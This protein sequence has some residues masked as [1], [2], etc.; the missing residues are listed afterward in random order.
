MAL[1][2]VI[3]EQAERN[4]EAIALL[5]PGRAPLRYGQLVRHCERVAAELNQVGIGR[6]DRVAVVLPNG[7]EMAACFLSVMMTAICAPL[8]P[9]YRTNE[10]EYLLAEPAPAVLIVEEGSE[11]AAVAV[12]E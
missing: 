8:N 11:S 9:A 2:R 4:P 10:F 6:R 1:S 7:P 3:E 12:A 5:A